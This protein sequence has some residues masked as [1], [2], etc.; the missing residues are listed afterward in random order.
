MNRN[1]SLFTDSRLSSKNGK[2][3]QPFNPRHPFWSTIGTA[4]FTL[5]LLFLLHL[6]WL[7]LNKDDGT[8]N[9]RF[10]EMRDL[11]AELGIIICSFVGA[12]TAYF[13]RRQ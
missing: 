5:G 3:N 9:R 2:T 7:W 13:I 4:C 8:F 12:W 11:I 1:L 10:M 6:V